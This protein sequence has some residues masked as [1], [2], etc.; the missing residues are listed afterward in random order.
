MNKWFW[1]RLQIIF[2]TW[3]YWMHWYFNALLFAKVKNLLQWV[4]LLPMLSQKLKMF[5]P[6]IF[7]YF[8]ALKTVKW[9]L[10]LINPYILCITSNIL[11][12]SNDKVYGKEPQCILPIPWPFA[13]LTEFNPKFGSNQGDIKQD[14]AIQELEN[15]QSNLLGDTSVLINYVW[16]CWKAVSCTI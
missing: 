4:M 3:T 14:R 6:D 9:N 11:Y 2:Y 10:D 15:L 12:P 16:S 5:C 13:I 1:E 7:I 8:L